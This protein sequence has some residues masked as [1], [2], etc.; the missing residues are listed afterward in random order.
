MKK[1]LL[2][3]AGALMFGSAAAQ[4]NKR[5]DETAGGNIQWDVYRLALKYGDPNVALYALYYE[6][7]QKPED[8]ALKDSLAS[9]YLQLGAYRQSILVGRE[10][11]AVQPE[12]RK[13]LEL[14]SLSHE[15]IG[16]VKEAL[17]YSERL[18]KL[19][20]SATQLYKIGTQ[21][22]ALKRYGECMGTIQQLLNHPQINTEKVT[23]TIPRTQQTPETRQ[24]ISLKAAAYNIRGAVQ[25][26]QK[27]LEAAR[28]SFNE[29]LKVEP[30]FQLAKSNLD[31]INRKLEKK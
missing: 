28:D 3:I 24:E 7:A 5:P 13:M 29:A 20:G 8:V 22:Y 12:N 26:D 27:E 10:I 4:K 19:N 15:A 6:L 11:L 2:I 14:L 17:D 1:L 16:A 18:Y 25:V 9:L 30:T 31:E 23:I 21:Q